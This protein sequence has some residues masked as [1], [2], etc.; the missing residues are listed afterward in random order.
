MQAVSKALLFFPEWLGKKVGRVVGETG[1]L[2]LFLRDNVIFVFHKPSRFKEILQQ[3]EFIGNQSV[4]I[5]LLTGVFT[6]LAL[7][8]QIYIGFQLVNASNLVGPTMA[9]GVTKELAPVLTGLVV[10]ARAGGAMA[11]QLGTMRVSEQIDALEVMSVNPKQ[12]LVMPRIVASVL[13]LPILCAFFDFLALLAA[14]WLCAV[15]LNLDVAIFWD[16]IELWVQKKDV[17]E[18]LVKASIFGLVFSLVCC[19]RGFDTVGG[20]KGVGEATN[21]GVVYSMV[22]IIIFNFFISNIYRLFMNF[23]D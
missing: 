17:V 12:Y 6:G 10:A 19:K 23:I 15:V 4:G 9:L 20:A 11:A 7:A 5:I 3:L 21:K 18:G 22:L 14:Q 16:K 8:Y 2:C 13:A 1:A